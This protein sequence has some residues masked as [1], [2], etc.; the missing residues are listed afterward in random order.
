[1]LDISYTLGNETDRFSSSMDITVIEKG[2]KRVL[3]A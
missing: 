3:L 1:M 2:V